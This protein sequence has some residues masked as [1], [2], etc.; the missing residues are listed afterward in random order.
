MLGQ[1]IEIR[2][3]EESDRKGEAVVRNGTEIFLLLEDRRRALR[4]GTGEQ[5]NDDEDEY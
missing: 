5:R 2:S 4:D 1:V 3:I